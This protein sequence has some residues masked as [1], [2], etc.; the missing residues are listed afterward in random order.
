MDV[1]GFFFPYI[2]PTK[3]NIARELPEMF[4]MQVIFINNNNKKRKHIG[5]KAVR[6]CPGKRAVVNQIFK[7]LTILEKY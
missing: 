1:L 5:H 6:C 2:K 3:L 4:L 7:Q